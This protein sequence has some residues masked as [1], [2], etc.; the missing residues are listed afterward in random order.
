MYKGPLEIF[1]ASHGFIFRGNVESEELQTKAS[2]NISLLQ[3]PLCQGAAS[4]ATRA[5]TLFF[6]LGSLEQA[7]A[8]PFL[9]LEPTEAS[10]CP[11]IHPGE[12]EP[13]LVYEGMPSKQQLHHL[14]NCIQL[15]D[16]GKF[17]RTLGSVL[18]MLSLKG[19]RVAW[20]V[21]SLSSWL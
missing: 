1:H 12:A 3:V 11:Q 5:V 14:S 6:Q 2:L 17:Q 18:R 10:L 8:P 16:A 21:A 15:R 13:P 9:H 19:T 7:P 20:T 4:M